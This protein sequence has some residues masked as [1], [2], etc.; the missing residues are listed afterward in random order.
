MQRGEHAPNVN[1]KNLGNCQNGVG[2]QESSAGSFVCAEQKSD[3]RRGGKHALKHAKGIRPCGKISQILR[4]DVAAVNG[5]KGSVRLA[6]GAPKKRPSLAAYVEPMDIAQS[7]GDDTH[8]VVI[9]LMWAREH[10]RHRGVVP[11]V[12]GL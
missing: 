9:G 6:I 8:A 4:I 10:V 3:A 12:G 5:P 7:L 11:S 2:F 1:S